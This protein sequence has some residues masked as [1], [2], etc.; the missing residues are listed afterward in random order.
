[1]Q[2]ELDMCCICIVSFALG[3]FN[4]FDGLL[5]LQS[6]GMHFDFIY[7][8]Q[9]KGS[10]QTQ[11]YEGGKTLPYLPYLPY[12]RYHEDIRTNRIGSWNN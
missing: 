4:L 7:Y 10:F 8:Y 11:H 6:G 3:I 1:M 12:L 5:P 9:A 2:L